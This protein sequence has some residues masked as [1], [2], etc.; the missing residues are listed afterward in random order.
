MSTSPKRGLG[1]FTGGQLTTIVCF[2]VAAVAFPMGAWAVSG[3]NSFITDAKSGA[4]A[5]VS[6]SGALNVAGT[7]IAG[8]APLKD[9]YHSW[10]GIYSTGVA[11]ATAPAGHSLVVTSLNLDV[12]GILGKYTGA[13]FELDSTGTSCSGNNPR[14]AEISY[15]TV[16]WTS[17]SIPSGL[18]IPPNGA[19]CASSADDAFASVFGYVM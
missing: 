13:F 4:H 19:L 16:G 12:A 3:S 15:A 18:D 7:V 9:M 5:T 1:P 8:A 10:T 2:L 11:I 17:V 6:K 14:V